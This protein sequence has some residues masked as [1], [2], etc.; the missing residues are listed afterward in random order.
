VPDP[1]DGETEADGEIEGLTDELGE[2]EW[3]GLIEGETELDGLTH[4]GRADRG[5]HAGGPIVDP[6]IEG[7]LLVPLAPYMLSSRPIV[8]ASDRV[9]RV[10][11]ESEKPAKL[12]LD[13]QRTKELQ[14]GSVLTVVRS[15]RPALFVDVPDVHLGAVTQALGARR[16]KMTKMVNHKMTKM[17]N[18]GGGRVRMEFEVPSR[19]LVGF[20]SE[21]L[22]RPISWRKE[23]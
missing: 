12:V 6:R 13:G 19:G 17:V 3:L 15:P 22:L 5:A 4:A 9:L 11:L 21:F 7:F 20:R 2:T 18:H 14:R 23:G 16:A 1:L 10:T 8:I